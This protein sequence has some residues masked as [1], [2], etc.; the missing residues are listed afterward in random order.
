M[1]AISVN[2][3]HKLFLSMNPC[4]VEAEFKELSLALRIF[5]LHST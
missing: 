4:N 1:P 2:N 3:N 5:T